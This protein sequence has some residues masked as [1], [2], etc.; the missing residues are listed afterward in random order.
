M[1]TRRADSI[2][3]ELENMILRG[4]FS[5]GDRL[6]E[7]KLAEQFGVSRTPIR[8][9]LHRLGTAG[10]VEQIPRRGVFV[11]HPGPIELLSLFEYMAELEA[12]CGRLAAPLISDAALAELNRANETCEA[13]L[14]ANDSDGYYRENERF[15]HIIY[16]ECGNSFLKTDAERLHRRLKPFRRVQ[17]QARGRLAQSMAE[18]RAIVAALAAGDPVR[19][20]DALRDHVAVQGQKFHH[21]LAGLRQVAE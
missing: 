20:A 9:A 4:A 11:R 21:L 17:L 2:A 12:A 19:S 13:A 6:N 7:I 14:A 10:L 16:T 15:H 3:L 8:E 1:D 18:H 5:D